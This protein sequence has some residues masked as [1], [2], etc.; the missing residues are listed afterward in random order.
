MILA[1][2]RGE[3]MRPLTDN[4]PKPL[5]KIA[6][7]ALIEYHIEALKKAG[8]S[9]IVINHAYLGHKLE[10]HLG[11]G[12]KY[13]VRIS[14]S[15]E[16][17][18][19]ETGGGILKALPI[20]GD[21]PFIVVNGDVWCD[22]DFSKLPSEILGLAHLVMIPNPQHNLKGDF[23]YANGMLSVSGNTKLTY[24]GIGVY[25]SKLFTNCQQGRFPLAPLLRNAIEEG[26]ISAEVHQNLWMDVGTP[27]RLDLLDKH[28][29]ALNN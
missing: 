16:G 20:L 14:Y 19:L 10:A 9:E 3:R 7:K 2:G 25:S 11:N 21:S 18:A 24:S 29:T 6:G 4:I 1:A 5:L 8:V 22:Y 27:E 17:E 23:Y 28:F 13:G 26:M 12:E 15:A